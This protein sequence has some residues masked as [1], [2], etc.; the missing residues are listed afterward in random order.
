MII[1]FHFVTQEKNDLHEHNAKLC[2]MKTTGKPQMLQLNQL[3]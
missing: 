3:H 2:I 1:Q